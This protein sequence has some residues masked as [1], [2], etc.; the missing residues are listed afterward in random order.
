MKK[1]VT[2]R[3][4]AKYL[5]HSAIAAAFFKTIISERALG[6]VPGKNL[7]IFS[8]PNGHKNWQLTRQA[9]MASR[10]ANRALLC[11]GMYYNTNGISHG[12]AA[13]LL[14]FQAN[15]GGSFDIDLNKALGLKTMR[16]SID[17]NPNQ[18]ADIM[19]RDANGQLGQ[20]YDNPQQAFGQFFGAS[21]E[22]VDPGTQND[23]YAGRKS[24]VDHCLDDVNRLKSEL[25]S[26]G[27][28]FDDNMSALVDLQK[29][30]VAL[31]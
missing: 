3:Q 21:A 19:C 18:N 11:Q 22:P 25:G 30:I 2:R 12:G 26:M 8:H 16:V 31:Q 28:L 13:N 1:K 15:Q 27:S 24:I 4:F 17:F 10:M 23:I 14:R 29:E 9:V 20:I 5:S 7:V 6:A